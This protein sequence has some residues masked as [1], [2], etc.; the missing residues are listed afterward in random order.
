VAITAI[1]DLQLKAD[2]L[3]TA[4]QVIRDTL[5]ATRAFPGCLSV[6]VLLDQGDPAHVAVVESWESIEH[7]GAYRAW[8]ATPEGASALGSI[9]AARPTLTYF[10]PAEDI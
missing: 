8:R 9:L 6:T 2:A 3:E 7:D 5:T 10:T 1:L 4:H